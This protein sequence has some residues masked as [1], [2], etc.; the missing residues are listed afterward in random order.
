MTP[1]PNPLPWSRVAR[2]VWPPMFSAT[3]MLVPSD[4]LVHVTNRW[5]TTLTSMVS[6]SSYVLPFSGEF[7]KETPVTAGAS[8]TLPSTLWPEPPV[9][10]EWVRSAS[11]APSAAALMVPPLR[12]MASAATLTP[13]ASSSSATTVYSKNREL[14]LDFGP[15]VDDSPTDRVSAPTVSW[16]WGVPVIVT[17]RSK[18][19]LTSIGSPRW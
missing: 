14:V 3:W 13:S 12:R 15:A 16:T 10:A 8:L 5:N 11:V 19:T 2:A 6:P 17:S 1:P 7:T 18:S 9:S 4:P